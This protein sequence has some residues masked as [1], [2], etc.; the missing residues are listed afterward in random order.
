MQVPAGTWENRPGS[1]YPRL[2]QHQP[3]YDQHGSVGRVL[4]GAN[5][6]RSPPKRFESNMR[7]ETR[8]GPDRPLD[9]QI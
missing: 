2:R 5:V 9:V 3:Q 7:D 6:A 4:K 1:L 8:T